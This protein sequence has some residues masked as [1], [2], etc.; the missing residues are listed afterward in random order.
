[1]D[2]NLDALFAIVPA[3]KAKKVFFALRETDIK[4]A[5]AF[6]A[7]GTAAKHWLEIFSISPEKDFVLSFAQHKITSTALEKISKTL[8][9]QNPGHGIS[10]TVPMSGVSGLR[11]FAYFASLEEIPEKSELTSSVEVE[12]KIMNYEY[13]VIFTVVNQGHSDE[14]VLAAKEAGA[15]GGTVL[16]AHG[17]GDSETAKFFGIIIQPE[18]DVVVTL[19]PSAI[20]KKVMLAI[21]ENAGL[22]KKGKGISFSMPVNSVVGLPTLETEK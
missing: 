19:V 6:K 8:D 16:S 14:V 1:M 3:G 2:K 21:R 7:K 9:M 22:S 20:R 15:G 5:I 10:F 13:D 17:I 18:K 4:H 11:T 12:E